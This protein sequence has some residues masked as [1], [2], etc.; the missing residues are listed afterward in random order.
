[1]MKT[2]VYVISQSSE[3]ILITEQTRDPEKKTFLVI[4]LS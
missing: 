2:A 1:M 4:I 3:L